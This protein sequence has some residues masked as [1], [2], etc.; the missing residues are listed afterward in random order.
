MSEN[1]QTR[2]PALR[3]FQFMG[4]PL[5]MYAV[6]CVILCPVSV[7]SPGNGPEDGYV[8]SHGV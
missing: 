5:A 2:L 1:K 4:I 8:R 3:D 7:V 6:I